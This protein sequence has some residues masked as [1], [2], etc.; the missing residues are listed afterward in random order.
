MKKL[1]MLLVIMLIL[2]PMVLAKVYYVGSYYRTDG[3]FVNGHLK[4]T[5]NNSIYDNLKQE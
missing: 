5:P 1:L 3:T 2:S 4:S